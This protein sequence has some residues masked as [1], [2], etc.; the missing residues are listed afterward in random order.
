[1]IWGY[2][3]FRKPPYVHFMKLLPKETPS[4]WCQ[5]WCHDES[6]ACC[7][8][9]AVFESPEW[10]QS[11]IPIHSWL[12]LTHH[13][14]SHLLGPKS[15]TLDIR[16]L[17]LAALRWFEFF[18]VTQWD[19]Q[20]W[21]KG[22]SSGHRSSYLML[23]ASECQWF[24][25][26]FLPWTLT[27]PWICNDLQLHSIWRFPKMGIPPVIIHFYRNFMEFPWN[28][29]FVFGVV[30]RK[31][32]FLLSHRSGSRRSAPRTS[33]SWQEDEAPGDWGTEVTRTIGYVGYSYGLYRII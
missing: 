20:N 27:N 32:P 21:F 2:H 15:D 8:G 13:A 30:P 31:S 24:F 10:C 3:Y 14:G 12:M 5:E 33:R 22:N 26:P 16:W 9:P 7:E 29:P 17:F 23:N 28:K 1:M 25:L 18:L 4:A 11:Q 6:R 19:P